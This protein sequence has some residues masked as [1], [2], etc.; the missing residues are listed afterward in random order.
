MLFRSRVIGRWSDRVRALVS[1]RIA[2]VTQGDLAEAHGISQSAV[3]QTLATAGATTII[4]AYAQLV[5]L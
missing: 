3:S 1:G 4:L 5:D 2:G